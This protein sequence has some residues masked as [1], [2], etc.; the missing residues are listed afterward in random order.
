[1]IDWARV[2]TLRDE[3]G[4]DDF[5]EVVDIFMEEVDEMIEHLRKAPDISNLEKDL[6]FLKGSAL[7]LGFRDFS[8]LCQQGET[9]SAN[10]NAKAV[11]VPK[12]VQIYDASKRTFVKDLAN[13]LVR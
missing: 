13:A 12:I 7:N 2:V 4:A 3:V 6:H 5:D 10:G 11:D 1:M 8:N 9:L